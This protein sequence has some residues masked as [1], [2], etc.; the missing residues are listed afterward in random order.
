MAEKARSYKAFSKI[1][2]VPDSGSSYFLPRL[3]GLQKTTYDDELIKFLHMSFRTNRNDL[4][5]IF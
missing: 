4:Q 5:S 2:L 3:I 1:G